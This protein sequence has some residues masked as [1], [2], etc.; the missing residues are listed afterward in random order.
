MVSYYLPV[1][2]KIPKH[3]LDNEANLNTLMVL[4]KVS[5]GGPHRPLP[6]PLDFVAL[7]EIHGN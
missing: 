3:D 6:M 4:C 2:S 1:V 7:L 5:L